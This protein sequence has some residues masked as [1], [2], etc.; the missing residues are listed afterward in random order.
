LQV[1]LD[2]ESTL[3]F[4]SVS[5]G[6]PQ[7]SLQLDIDTGSSDIW[8]NSALSTLC[9]QYS[10]EC[11]TSGTYNANKS[12]SYKY[13]SSDFLIKYADGSY[14]QGD[15]ATDTLNIG[16]K[17]IGSVPFGI[18]YSSTSS[19]GILGLGYAANEATVGTS[20]R[21]YHNLPEILA[22]AGL[23]S[24]VAYS[25]WLNDLDANTGSVLF[26]GVDTE[27]YQGQLQTLPIIQE[28]GEYREF[29]IAL[30]S[31]T[32]AGQTIISSSNPVAVLLDSGSSLSYLPDDAAQSLFN[33]LNAQ[34]NEQSGAAVVDC[35]LRDSQ[36][37]VSFGF[38]G[39]TINVPMDEL[40]I[41]DSVRRGQETCILGMCFAPFTP[42]P[43]PPLLR[44]VSNS[45]TRHQRRRRL[46]LR[47]RRHLPPQRL[48]SLRSE[49]QPNLPRP[50]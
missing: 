23:T 18:G 42:Y 22:G 1:T 6:T 46:H 16:G 12:S 15:Y 3:Y 28:A 24:S 49:Q 19:Q 31:V 21:I 30:T 43:L 20:G 11:S 47:P 17:N 38:S 45:S 39:V 33:V 34:Y 13:T 36:Q 4:A 26:G 2:N 41:V 25:L 40:V 29:F 9:Q 50:D 32:A 44:P 37:T 5:L 10:Q 48:R 35:G 7:Q 14:A 8:A 27:K